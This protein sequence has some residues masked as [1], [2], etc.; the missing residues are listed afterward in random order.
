[1]DSDS[2]ERSSTWLRRRGLRSDERRSSD[3]RS[4]DRLAGDQRNDCASRARAPVLATVLGALLT[5]CPPLAPD[6]GD[7]GFQNLTDKTNAGA[8]YV[9]SAAC[10]QCHPQAAARHALHG[11]A[12]I[13]TPVS[14]APPEFPAEAVDGAGGQSAGVPSPPAGLTW[15]DIAYVLGGYRKLANFI[16]RDGFLL[17]TGRA[18]ADTQFNLAFPPNAAQPGFAPFRPDRGEP[19]PYEFD[20]FRC[21]TT[22]PQPFSPGDPQF[23]DSRP[24][25]MGT[26][27]EAGVQCESC[28]G[29]GGNHFTTIG[30]QVVIRL[31]R[32][33]I[34]PS[35]EQ[36][37]FECHAG[38][39]GDASAIEAA[40]GFILFEQQA[41][42]LRASGGHAGFACQVCHE[43]HA[44]VTYDRGAAIRNACT[45]CHSDVTMARHN[46][47][48]Y[49]SAD[50]YAETLRCESCHMPLAT[51]A[52]TSATVPSIDAVDGELL[53][54]GRIGDTRTHIFRITTE[55]LDVSA[56]ITAGGQVA[57][58]EAGRAA[59]TVDFA[60][61]RCHNGQGNVFG[62][63]V[64]RAAEIAGRIH[65]VPAAP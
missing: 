30:G 16:D 4:S 53:G 45:V 46:G 38:R 13:L 7:P 23:Q 35:G 33:F 14:G 55:P 50:G 24:G 62:L 11:H 63:S 56:M 65:E 64:E 40:N 42:E 18:G 10:R 8:A 1:M 27:L 31:D 47:A 19:L 29:P 34:D 39:D 28:H 54:E 25:L 41:A 37:C 51:R 59:V 48:V 49:R 17:T 52:A 44:S 21:H 3:R 61:L 12:N 43:P 2:R 60:C 58:D 9:G 5:G 57:R 6:G 22:N 15:T 36:T 20:C 26:W 32:I